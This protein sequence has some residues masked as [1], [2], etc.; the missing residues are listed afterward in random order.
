MA[1]YFNLNIDNKYIYLTKSSVALQIVKTSDILNIIIP[2]FDK[3]TIQGLK[4]L[5][6]ADFKK[7]ATAIGEK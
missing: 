1:N 6:F 4:S 2:F 7:V 3:Y 5:D